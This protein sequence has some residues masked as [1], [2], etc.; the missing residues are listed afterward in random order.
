M[1]LQFLKEKDK[2]EIRENVQILTSSFLNK[3]NV[4]LKQETLRVV[5]K[6]RNDLLL[7][8]SFLKIS[9]FSGASVKPIRSSM[10]EFFAKV[11]SFNNRAT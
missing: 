6:N 1:T 7:L 9:L 10:M 8:G 5:S 3:T 11:I 4:T 2:K